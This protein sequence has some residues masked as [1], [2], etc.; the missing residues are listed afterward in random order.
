MAERFKI[1]KHTL[2]NI[3]IS[4][5]DEETTPADEDVFVMQQ[6][7]GTIVKVKKENVGGGGG[8]TVVDKSDT[9]LTQRTNLK[10]FQETADDSDNDTTKVYPT[11]TKAGFLGEYD[12]ENSGAAKTIDWNNGQNQKITLTADCTLSFTALSDI[13][14]STF[15]VQLKVIQDGT[16]GWNLYFPSG[17]VF[18]NGAFDSSTGTANQTCLVGIYYDGTKYYVIPTLWF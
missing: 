4:G 8:H 13:N 6:V 9:S 18:C 12:N 10:L 5:L 7:D 2:A 3:D 17:T 14:A 1:P 16:G 15:R 11:F